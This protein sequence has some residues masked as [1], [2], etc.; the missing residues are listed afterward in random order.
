VEHGRNGFLVPLKHPEEI[1]ERLLE[2]NADRKKM[3]RMGE[4]ARETVLTRY[5]TDKIVGQY[6]EVYEKVISG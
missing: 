4:Q 2:L 1:A 6:L 5:A 3:R